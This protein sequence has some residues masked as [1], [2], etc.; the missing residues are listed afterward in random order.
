MTYPTYTD[1][2]RAYE[3]LPGTIYSNELKGELFHILAGGQENAADTLGDGE[4]DES[5]LEAITLTTIE[6][7]LC[8]RSTSDAARAWAT[9][10]GLKF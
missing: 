7:S 2:N 6:I 8:E 10:Q 4:I 1:L 5:E 9:A 3:A